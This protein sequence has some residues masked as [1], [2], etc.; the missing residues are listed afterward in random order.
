MIDCWFGRAFFDCSGR[1]PYCEY[2]KCLGLI[3]PLLKDPD[4]GSCTPGFYIN[5]IAKSD[6][7]PSVRLSYFTKDGAKTQR[8]IQA[9]ADSNP[10]VRLWKTVCPHEKTVSKDYGG[11]ELR[12]R[13]FLHTYTQIGLDL[14]D[15]DCLYSRRLAA[16]YRLEYSP[17]GKPCRELFER[18]LSKYS[19]FFK[20]LKELDN[21]AVE[22]LW[23]DLEFWHCDEEGRI[24]QWVHF[25]VNMLLP[26]DPVSLSPALYPA[27]PGKI[28]KR[29]P[30]T[31]QLREQIL[32]AW[33]LD[34]PDDWTPE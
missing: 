25:L 23:D 31:G 6:I 16:K 29:P 27:I 28:L 17:Q 2:F 30:V 34:L 24:Q 21:C 14:L 33:K 12:F 7:R 22:Q 11:D 9:F 5:Y 19:N 1:Q 18:A 32:K 10:D 13:N 15:Y 8:V 26:G 3:R 4:F 20:E